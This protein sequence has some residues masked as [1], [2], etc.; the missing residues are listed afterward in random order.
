MNKLPLCFY[1]LF[2]ALSGTVFAQ[3]TLFLNIPQR[4]TGI[5]L[6]FN[7]T[8]LPED[9]A[10]I[11]AG[12][13]N[14]IFSITSKQ[15][16]YKVS[17]INTEGNDSVQLNDL[18]RMYKISN[19]G[20]TE[21]AAFTFGN[22]HNIKVYNQADEL[23]KV[24]HLVFRPDDRET[25][26]SDAGALKQSPGIT[27]YQPGSAVVDAL[28]LADPG[29]TVAFKFQIL[30]HYA[31]NET[32]ISKLKSLYNNNKFLDSLVNRITTANLPRASNL[33]STAFSSVG[34]LDVT[35]VADALARFLVKRTKQELSAA[36]FD[37]FKSTLDSIRDL[38][39][40]F[41]ET[42]ALLGSI[43]TDVYNYERYIQNLRE[44]FIQDIS[45]LHRNFPGIIDNH[46]AFFSKHQQLSASLL[47]ACYVASE[48]ENQAHPGDI[49]ASYPLEFLDSTA[50]GYPPR[51]QTY[52][53]AIQTVQLISHSMRNTASPDDAEY[54]VNISKIR[55]LVNNRTA[56]KFYLGLLWQEAAFKFDSI[57]FGRTTTLIQQL[58]KV[59]AVYD[60]GATVY[61]A[62]KTYILRFGVKAD[63]LNNMISKH[64]QLPADSSRLEKYEKYFRACIDL[65][66]YATAISELP[67]LADIPVVQ[68][69]SANMKPWF[70]I[71]Y[72]TADMV[73]DINKR[74]YS[75]AVNH[76]VAI[77][78]EIKA[79]PSEAG[80][81]PATDVEILTQPKEPGKRFTLKSKAKDSKPAQTEFRRTLELLAKYGGFMSVVASAKTSAEMEQ[82]IEVFALPA[83][84]SRIK[85]ASGFNV[86]FNAYVGLFT[87]YE[88]IKGV[89]NKFRFNAYGVT[90]PLGISISKGIYGTSSSLF[91]SFIDIGAVTAFR[92]KDDVAEKVPKVQLKDI[93]SPGVFYSFGFPRSPL[94]ANIGYQVGP[95]LRKVNLD[96]NLY[97]EKYSRFS[98]SLCV[99]IP[100]L[101]FYTRTGD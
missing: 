63:A 40:L 97:E 99:D 15:P 44:G 60:K 100:V 32:D 85:R 98:V 1:L 11:H 49:L 26:K 83:G 33:L 7:N 54:W 94:S 10:V 2:T 96:Q 57:H 31:N 25:M 52:R 12:G 3:D 34:G 59:A 76:A 78:N 50:A 53:A 39:T 70:K 14:W 75:S 18:N 35:N 55:E 88:K 58:N 92:F 62:Y 81:A 51:L 69:L 23:I 90:A 67:V 37:R 28:S 74:N 71:A 17:V 79:S 84:S 13:S 20:L 38:Q 41:P 24:Y 4:K 19:N 9:R 42:A 87:G 65:I 68:N 101:N 56:L 36:F 16:G 93:I 6:K 30:S 47:S 27:S 43:G 48:L 95:L 73:I 77:Y 8:I 61:H 66:E 21:P 91:L 82:A 45:A 46:P 86:A 29:N 89:D 80:L 72:S 64:K 5:S 22:S